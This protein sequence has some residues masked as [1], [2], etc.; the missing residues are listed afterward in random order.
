MLKDP[1]HQVAGHK[2][3]GGKL[4]PLV[5]DSGRFY[6]PLQGD[7]RGKKEVAFY[8]SFSSNIKVPDHISRFF[9]K[10]YGTQLVEASDG[11]SMQPH[12]VLQDLTFNRV[13]PSVMDIKIGS[14]TW[15]PEAPAD[16]KQKCMKK[17]RESSS[18]PLGFRLSGLQIFESGETGFWKPDKKWVQSLPADE[19]RLLL[20]K[21]VSSNTSKAMDSKPD[22]AFASIVYG[23]STGILSQILELKAWFED[24]TIYHFYSCSVLLMF[25]KEL[26]SHGKSPRS[27]I[28]L[29]DFAH[30]YEGRGVIDHNFLGGLC[31]LIKFISEILTTPEDYATD[32][33]L[34]DIQ[35]NHNYSA[36]GSV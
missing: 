15:A 27:E 12:L 3:L 9:P 2:A 7:E 5:D 32:G 16:Y 8:T 29:I 24:Q 21:F 6:K 28:K 26:A 18:L 10:F 36:N 34:E 11:S 4:G 33:L 35:S 31:S 23:G 14:R 19:V 17:D 22:C 1:D 30:V 20:K 25:E 13:N